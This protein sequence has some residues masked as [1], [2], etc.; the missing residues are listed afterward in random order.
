MEKGKSKI[1]EEYKLPVQEQDGVMLNKGKHLVIQS[2]WGHM[3]Q[4]VQI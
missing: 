2:K 4:N 3:H 1:L